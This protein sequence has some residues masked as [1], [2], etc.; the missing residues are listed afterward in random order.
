MTFMNILKK[1]S[2]LIVAVL[3]L[4]L[5]RMGISYLTI[6]IAIG[7]V[8][9]IICGNKKSAVFTGVLYATISYILTYPS[10]LFLIDYMPSESIPITVPISTVYSN[11]FFGWI[12]PVI[13]AIV[14]CGIFSIFGHIIKKQLLDK[15]IGKGSDEHYFDESNVITPNNNNSLTNQDYQKTT[16]TINNNQD[17]PRRT[18]SLNKNEKKELLYLTPIQKAKNRNKRKNE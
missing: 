16:N 15:V 8:M 13:I 14:V 17:Y 1:I 6:L 11:I 2:I 3:S 9:P 4:E 12:I 10:S 5:T 18:N 7:I